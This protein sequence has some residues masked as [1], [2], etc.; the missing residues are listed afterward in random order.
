MGEV[1]MSRRSVSFRRACLAALLLFAMAAPARAADNDTRLADA[2][3]RRDVAA[4]RTLIGQ[5]V[6]ANTPGQDGTPALHWAVRV[7]DVAT[8]K[9]L[10]GA[11]AQ[12]TLANRY[13]LTPLAHRGRQWQRRDDRRAARRRCGRERSRSRW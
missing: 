6:D 11:G 12:A 1:S 4:V 10:L 2:A 3:M 9:L 5:K 8:A 7:D 13:G